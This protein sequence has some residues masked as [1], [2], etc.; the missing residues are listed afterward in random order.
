MT[1]SVYMLT[2]MQ[3]LSSISALL[4]LYR[5]ENWLHCTRASGLGLFSSSP[6][7]QIYVSIRQYRDFVFMLAF[8]TWNCANIKLWQMTPMCIRSHN[9]VNVEPKY[10]DIVS[11]P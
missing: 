1:A 6:K 10:R 11:Y 2:S 8:G 3:N 7:V 9:I 5:L 4:A